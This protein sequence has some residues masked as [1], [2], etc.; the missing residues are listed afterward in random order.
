MTLAEAIKRPLFCGK[1]K[2]KATFFCFNL[3]D[4]V[5]K[6]TREKASLIIRQSWKKGLYFPRWTQTDTH[7]V[8]RSI[9]AI[10]AWVG[11]GALSPKNMN[12]EK[13][14]S[15]SPA[16]VHLFSFCQRACSGLL[17]LRCKWLFQHTTTMANEAKEEKKKSGGGKKKKLSSK[18]TFTFAPTA[19]TE[20]DQ[21]KK[22][23]ISD[24]PLSKDF[25]PRYFFAWFQ[26][27][28]A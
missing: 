14:K 26:G 27:K 15:R 23:K 7:W 10:V 28:K 1:S 19:N 11:E 5:I 12:P 3:K 16:V 25:F 4:K 20:V 17:S 21:R 18:S 6:N 2:E 8:H 24:F 22:E 9:A 13:G